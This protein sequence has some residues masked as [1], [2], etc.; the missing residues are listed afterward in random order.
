MTALVNLV[1]LNRW[2]LD[3]KRRKLADLERLAERLRE[4]LARLDQGIEAERR[5]AEASEDARQAYPAFI[6]AELQRR[7]RLED[8]IADVENELEDARDEVAIAFQELKK[9]ELALENQ[10]RRDREQQ[11]RQEQATLDEIGVDRHRR[12]K[13]DGTN[14]E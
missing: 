6:T 12:R 14:N 7:H 9:Y 4:D 5:A 13:S 10:R 8:S 2:H 11:E 3:E 1:R